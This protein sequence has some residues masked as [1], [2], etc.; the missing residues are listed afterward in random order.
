MRRGS[1]KQKPPGQSPILKRGRNPLH[2][3]RLTEKPGPSS[4][5]RILPAG[6]MQREDRGSFNQ[7]SNERP[8]MINHPRLLGP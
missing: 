4:K 2:S 7:E 6:K 1:W 8:L 3:S 5:E